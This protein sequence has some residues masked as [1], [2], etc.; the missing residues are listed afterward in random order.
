MTKGLS[1][2]TTKEITFFAASLSHDRKL[3]VWQ[4]G[5]YKCFT[6][7]LNVLNIFQLYIMV[8]ACTLHMKIN[9]AISTMGVY[10]GLYWT[11]FDIFIYS[12][13]YE[14]YGNSTLRFEHRAHF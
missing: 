12:I 6:F 4:F 1:G 11:I 5:K 14:N 3:Q 7:H 8:K 10:P 13:F 9:F 2:L